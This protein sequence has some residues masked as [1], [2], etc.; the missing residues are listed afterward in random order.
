MSLVLFPISSA[1]VGHS[2]IVRIPV[3][4]YAYSVMPDWAKSL[5]HSVIATPSPLV[6]RRVITSLGL[7]SIQVLTVVR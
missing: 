5:P 1:S 7:A 6:R 2:S 4:L 3:A